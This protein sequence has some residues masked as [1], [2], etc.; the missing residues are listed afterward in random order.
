MSTP[1]IK[2]ADVQGEEIS[3]LL[4]QQLQRHSLRLRPGATV[5]SLAADLKAAGL[6]LESKFGTL[7]GKVGD[8]VADVPACI[9]SFAAK[10]ADKFFARDVSMGIQSRDQLDLKGKAQFITKHGLAAFEQLKS[11]ASDVEPASLDP[12]KLTAAEY[13]R[14]SHATKVECIRAWGSDRI[15]AIMARR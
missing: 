13:K 12:S 8:V 7:C 11:K 14:L 6:T 5:A 10:N 3:N 15:A 4:E 9:E 1:T 2:P